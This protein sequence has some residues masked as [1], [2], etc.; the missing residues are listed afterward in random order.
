[1]L[2]RVFVTGAILTAVLAAA[3]WADIVHLRS[4]GRLEGVVSVEGDAITVTNKYG[5]T[6]VPLSA[7]DFV[8]KTPNLLEKYVALAALAPAGDLESQRK[9]TEFCRKNHLA[10]AE[11][12]HLLLILRLRPGD[13]KARSRLGYVKHRGRW[14]TKSDEMYDRGL[15]RFRG[16][17]V[18][19]DAKQAVLAEERERRRELAAKRRKERQERLAMLRAKRLFEAQKERE[20]KRQSAGYLGIG[21]VDQKYQYPPSYYPRY[22]GCSITSPYYGG[23]Y[24]PYPYGSTGWTWYRRWTGVGLSGDYRSGS[25]RVT[26]GR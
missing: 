20:K 11:R 7:V 22:G 10:S 17:W 26:W 24:S 15:T 1:M 14:V 4:G 16:G 3:A 23:C 25:W 5:S 18:T 6:S 8:E 19:P 9:L 12:Y 21:Y 2:F 13:I